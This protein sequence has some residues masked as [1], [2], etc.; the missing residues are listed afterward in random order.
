MKTTIVIISLFLLGGTGAIIASHPFRTPPTT[1]VLVLRD[2]TD[3]MSQQPDTV[4]ILSLYNLTGSNEW[5]GAQ[6]HFSDLSD[7]SYTKEVDLSLPP[8]NEWL[9]N[10]IDRGK[11]VAQFQNS[12]SQ[13]LI[14]A[15]K[16]PTG[17]Q[18]SSLYL[19]ISNE[20][21]SLNQSSAARRVIVICSD[22]MEN[23]ATISFYNAGTFQ[24]LKDD[25]A[26]IAQVLE[27][28]QPL[29][30]LNGI[31]IHLI[32][33]PQTPEQDEAYQVVAS[34]YR[35]LFEQQGATVTIGANLSN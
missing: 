27:Q 4:G 29:P 20:L 17:K 24:K 1:D 8:A 12:V 31:E 18:Q 6:F 28:I 15:E 22:L 14:I 16:E 25:P 10:E 30:S 32:Y 9:S 7:V 35:N 11:E 26:A 33:A 5:N 3:P 2:I 34:F 13:T 23:T 21:I 19:P